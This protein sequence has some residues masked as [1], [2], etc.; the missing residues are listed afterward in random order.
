MLNSD[1]L[2]ELL[3]LFSIEFVRNDIPLSNYI[4]ELSKCKDMLILSQMMTPEDHRAM[5]V[6]IKDIECRHRKTMTDIAKAFK[7]LL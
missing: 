3:Q 5:Q 2:S 6:I 1:L 7:I 4:F